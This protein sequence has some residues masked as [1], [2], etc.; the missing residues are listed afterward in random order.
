MEGYAPDDRELMREMR[1]T[2][3]SQKVKRLLWGLF[4]WAFLSAAV[5]IFLMYQFFTLATVHGPGMGETAPSGSVLLV[6]RAREGQPPARGDVVLIAREESWEIKR[7]AAVGGDAVDQ[8]ENGCLTI[9]GTAIAG[10]NAPWSAELPEQPFTVPEGE[11]FVLGDRYGLSVDSRS[12]VF[13]TV[14]GENVV[15]TAKYILWPAYRIGEIR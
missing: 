10:Y 8:D 9:N 13:G 11:Y 6:R 2:R 3:R 4:I 15:G 5:G 7:V 1:R 12:P 14:R